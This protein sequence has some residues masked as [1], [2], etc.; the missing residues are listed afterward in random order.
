MGNE[1]LR[2][3]RII[4]FNLPTCHHDVIGDS[5]PSFP[6][7]P[8]RSPATP[9]WSETVEK[10]DPE[11]PR[12]GVNNSAVRETYVCLQS[13]LSSPSAA[14]TTTRRVDYLPREV[15]GQSSRAM[16]AMEVLRAIKM[17]QKQQIKIRSTI[18]SLWIPLLFAVSISSSP[19][20]GRP[21]PLFKGKAIAP[22][23]GEEQER[24]FAPGAH[25]VLFNDTLSEYI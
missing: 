21:L 12:G 15:T 18:F 1:L 7:F 13:K 8:N 20:P 10:L 16:M 9:L 2:T 14:K 6:S 22:R 5:Q 17:T 19:P 24:K 11:R 23:Q 3:S 4:D 25:H